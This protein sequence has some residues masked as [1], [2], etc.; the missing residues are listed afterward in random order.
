V[1]LIT[2]TCCRNVVIRTEG[3]SF[4]TEEPQLQCRLSDNRA[5]GLVIMFVL[6]W[7][8][9]ESMQ[10]NRSTIAGPACAPKRRFSLGLEKCNVLF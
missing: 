5:S 1:Q 7:G 8:P 6:P 4:G 9:F 10:C 3:T 2:L